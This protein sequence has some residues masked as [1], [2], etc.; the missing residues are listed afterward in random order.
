MARRQVPLG[1]FIA[2]TLLS[3]ACGGPLF[4]VKP[5]AD[6]PPLPSTSKRAEAGGVIVSVAPLMTDEESQELFEANLQASGILPIRMQF[7]FPNETTTDPRKIKFRLSDSQNREWKLL[8]TKSAVNRIMKA[9]EIKLYNPHSKKQFESDFGAYV[10]DLKAPLSPST[11]DRR[12]FL[13]FEAPKKV[14]VEKTGLTLSVER[15][16][17]PL[18]IPLN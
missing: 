18:S 13:F 14:P 3:V 7:V 8:S 4:K 2:V 12:G 17:T 10:L 9:E 15:L 5:A 6:L 16:P 1:V 11:L